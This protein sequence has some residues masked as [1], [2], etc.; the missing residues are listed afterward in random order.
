MN[1]LKS[2]SS[3][4]KYSTQHLKFLKL[5]KFGIAS[6]TFMGNNYNCANKY[7]SPYL[8]LKS[9]NNAFRSQMNF[10]SVSNESIKKENP[11]TCSS[12][13]SKPLIALSKNYY[14]EQI[15][16]P[17][18]AHFGYY[19]EANGKAFVVD[20]TRDVN[21]YL[22]LLKKRNAQLIYIGETHFHADFVSGHLEL[23]KE[24][25]AKIIYGPDAVADFPIVKTKDGMIF[26]LSTK[27]GIQLL[28]TPGHTLESCSYSI[29]EKEEKSPWGKHQ[30]HAV[31]TGDTLFL[32]EVG[33][34]DLAVKSGLTDHDLAAL[35]YNSLQK[36]KKLPNECQVLP[37]HGAGSACGKCIQKGNYSTIAEQKKTNFALNDNLKK[38]EFVEIATSN[39]STPPQYFFFD[40][41]MN[42]KNI[43]S[44]KKIIETGLK[45][46]KPK[47]FQKLSTEKDVKII[48]ARKNSEIF[49]DGIVPFSYC[50]DLSM[51]YAI[52][53]ATL[54][55]P[56]DKVL[57]ICDPNKEEEAITRLARVGFDNFIGVLEGGLKSWKNAG[58]PV[59]K[60]SLTKS[61]DFIKFL[62]K[63]SYNTEETILDV[64]NP[65]EHKQIGII[66]KSI[67]IPLNTLEKN[68]NTIPNNVPISILCKVGLRAS[69]AAS[70]LASKGFKNEIK[71]VEG[72]MDALMKDKTPVKLEKIN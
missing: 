35:L 53:A 31:M 63:P 14:I 40:V 19:I 69:I 58:L 60:I 45:Y 33:R 65:A 16:T 50:I 30:T 8:N 43:T 12:E 13:P 67:L 64:R 66:S 20:P 70:I 25:G 28:H 44:L 18:L 15:S 49:E 4:F 54:L 71:V 11:P 32:G 61:S 6:F 59:T 51:T 37:G 42:K 26:D 23:A 41:M 10:V 3:I 34:P 56:S 47:E 52:W 1:S 36:L 48:D 24:T 9:S 17:C 68:F 29:I 57:L 39:I 62:D 22:S 72:G 27:I 46:I 2:L 7:K 55:K 38:E 21:Y 5:R